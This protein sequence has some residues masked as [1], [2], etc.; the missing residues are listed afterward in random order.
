MSAQEDF[1]EEM[2]LPLATMPLNAV[3]QTYTVLARPAGGYS[4]GKCGNILK[5]TVKEVDPSTGEAE[6]QGFEDEYELMD[7]DISIS[8]YIKPEAVPNF[9]AAWEELGDATEVA[10]EYGLGERP[11]LEE[12]VEAV[13]STVGMEIC[14]GTDVIP[15]NARS[16]QVLLSGVFLGGVRCLAR[17]SFGIDSSRNVA[18]KVA[19]RGDSDEVAEAV[20]LIIQ[21]A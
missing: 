2:V 9:R 20:H 4:S 14:E 15:P 7:V 12:T 11:S 18:M 5:F 6:E 8:D 10:D 3:D 13:I 19:A 1:D 21:E 16:H 17:F